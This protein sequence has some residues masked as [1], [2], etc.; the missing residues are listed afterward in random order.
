MPLIDSFMVDHTVMPAPSV[1]KAKV[2]STPHGDLVEVWDLRFFHPNETRMTDSG[3]H[4]FE[5]LF[6]SFMREHINSPGVE[7]VDISPMGCKTGFYMSLIGDPPAEQVA[8]AMTEAMQDIAALPP[9]TKVP[10]ANPYQCGSY[11]M[12]SL[13]DAQ[14]IARRI[15]KLGVGVTR[16]EDIPLSEEKLRE[17]G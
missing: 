7:V 10:A 11:Q 2:M 17:L 6:A 13:P 5:H 1:R 14:E 16:N 4:T 12:H 9:D 15:I 8:R 3:T